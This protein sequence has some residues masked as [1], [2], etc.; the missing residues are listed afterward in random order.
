MYAQ[1]LRLLLQSD[2]RTSGTA[3]NPTFTL[4]QPLQHVHSIRM[5]KFVCP[6]CV[7]N[8]TS[9]VLVQFVVN[10]VAIGSTTVKRGAWTTQNLANYLSNAANWSPP[11]F[12]SILNPF[13]SPPGAVGNLVVAWHPESFNFSVQVQSYNLTAVG[14]GPGPLYMY[15]TQNGLALDL[16]GVGSGPSFAVSGGQNNSTVNGVSIFTLTNKLVPVD[17]GVAVYGPQ[18]SPYQQLVNPGVNHT[19]FEGAG[20]AFYTPFVANPGDF[21]EITRQSKY[22]QAFNFSKTTL[23]SVTLALVDMSNQKVLDNQGATWSIELEFI[24]VFD[25]VPQNKHH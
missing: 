20:V 23:A 13:P 21:V 4:P 3:E 15:F 6:N 24:S 16:L 17:V 12:T 1:P 18:I 8:V 14:P 11:S 10:S 7:P 19:L 2:N 9:D 25:H 5:R 22:E